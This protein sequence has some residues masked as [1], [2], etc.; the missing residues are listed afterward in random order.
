MVQL[1]MYVYP[2]ELAVRRGTSDADAGIDGMTAA[3]LK[4][5]HQL[6]ARDYRATAGSHYVKGE[7]G[8]LV[9]VDLLV[10]RTLNARTEELGGRTFD[11]IPGLGLALSQ[12]PIDL[13]VVA[14]LLAGGELKF[15]VPIPGIEVA[16]IMKALAM[17]TRSAPKDLADLCSL[18]EMAHLHK[19][20][21][22]WKLDKEEAVLKGHR[23]DG[24]RALHQIVAQVELGAV[25]HEPPRTPPPRMAALIKRH[26]A[27]P[28]K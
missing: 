2:C 7:D 24:A 15:S 26:V 10:P 14:R 21:L 4:L 5:H 25:A 17:Q 8:E 18:L 12:E 1:L 22:D 3:G 6:L 23:R 19:A 13:S 20:S 28:P 11:A 27:V 16:L 9:E